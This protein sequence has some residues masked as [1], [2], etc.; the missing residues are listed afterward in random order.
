[1]LLASTTD[2]QHQKFITDCS[3]PQLQRNLPEPS[4]LS[5]AAIG[6]AALLMLTRRKVHN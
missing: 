5:L 3:I 4:S 2:P 1:V 6:M